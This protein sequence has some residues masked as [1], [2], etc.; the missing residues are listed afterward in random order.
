MKEFVVNMNIR[1]PRPEL[2]SA[3]DNSRYFNSSGIQRLF[4]GG[5]FHKLVLYEA[6]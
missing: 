4:T 3:V 5:E 1:T 6:S 2:P